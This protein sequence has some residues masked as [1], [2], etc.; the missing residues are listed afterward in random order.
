MKLIIVYTWN[1]YQNKALDLYFHNH[2][3]TQFRQNVSY[4]LVAFTWRGMSLLFPL[5]S[6][7]YQQLFI[8]LH[9]DF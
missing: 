2:Q 4:D 8:L 9:N 5:T 6:K 1:I 3:K 7:T